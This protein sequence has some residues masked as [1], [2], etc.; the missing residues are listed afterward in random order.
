MTFTVPGL[1]GLTIGIGPH[2]PK[3]PTRAVGG[4]LLL[5]FPLDLR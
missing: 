2:S 1:S 3:P 5:A 4:G